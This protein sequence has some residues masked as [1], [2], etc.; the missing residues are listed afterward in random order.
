MAENLNFA[1]ESGSWCYEKEEANCDIYGRLYD[2]ATAMNIDVSYN[3]STY[4]AEAKHQGVCPTGWHLPSDAEWITL[5]DNTGDASTAGT[6]LKAA[7][8]WNSSGN[9]TDNYGFSALPGGN[10]TAAGAFGN[11]GTFARWWTT[12]ES[13]ATNATHRYIENRYSKVDPNNSNKQLGVSVRC[14]QD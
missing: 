10:R 5:I 7:S 11:L 4:T 14:V 3:T 2:W 13:T 8:G 9:G 6:K 12:T 1:T